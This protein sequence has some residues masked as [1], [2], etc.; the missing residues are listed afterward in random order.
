MIPASVK[1]LI[2]ADLGAADHVQDLALDLAIVAAGEEVV[3]ETAGGEVG[4]KEV[5]P[6]SDLKKKNI[7]KQNILLL[8]EKGA[9]QKDRLRKWLNP[10]L[11]AKKLVVL[12]HLMTLR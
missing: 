4:L 7:Q 6:G 10:I 9:L 5:G 1:E 8:R 3:L 2:K 12:M 11:L